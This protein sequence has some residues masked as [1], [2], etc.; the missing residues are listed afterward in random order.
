MRLSE[1]ILVKETPA[2]GIFIDEPQERCELFG[3]LVTW[4]VF[5]EWEGRGVNYIAA[6]YE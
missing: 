1:C 5:D 2:V 6:R 4:H 3:D